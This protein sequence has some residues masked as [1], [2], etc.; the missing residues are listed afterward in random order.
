MPKPDFIEKGIKGIHQ[1]S[2]GQMAQWVE[3][4]PQYQK[5]IDIKVSGAVTTIYIGWAFY[6]AASSAAEWMIQ[7]FVLDET[8]GLDA[9]SE[10]AGGSAGEFGFSWDDRASHSYS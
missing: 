1:A 8:D 5:R 7:R 6:G 3:Q 10:L 9:T 4:M 2:V